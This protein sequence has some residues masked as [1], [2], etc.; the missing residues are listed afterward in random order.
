MHLST[1][2]VFLSRHVFDESDF[3]F[4]KDPNVSMFQEQFSHEEAQAIVNQDYSDILTGI[5]EKKSSF[6]VIPTVLPSV[7]N[8]SIMDDPIAGSSSFRDDHISLEDGQDSTNV[9]R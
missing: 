7:N 4:G 6:E 2:H 9:T 3:P 5:D 1:G 8:V